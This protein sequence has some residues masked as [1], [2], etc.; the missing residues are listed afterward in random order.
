MEFHSVD[1]IECSPTSARTWTDCDLDTYIADLP[2]DV[3]G[4]QLSFRNTNTTLYDYQIAARCNGST[5]ELYKKLYRKTQT[6]V[7]IGVDASKIFEVKIENTTYIDVLISGYYTGTDIIF[8]VNPVDKSTATINEYVDV[9]CS[10]NVSSSAVGVFG[11]I[12]NNNVAIKNISIRKNGSTDDRYYGLMKNF[13]ALGFIIGIDENKIF[14]QKIESADI[15]IY[16]NGYIDSTAAVFNTNATD[17]SLTK[18]ATPVDLNALPSGA[19]AGIYEVVN[20]SSSSSYSYFLRKHGFTNSNYQIVNRRNY[21]VIEG[22]AQGQIANTTV[23]FWL[24]GYFL[25]ENSGQIAITPK[26]G[27]MLKHIATR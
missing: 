16:I 13:S 25:S 18:T 6:T 15:D 1:L 8:F 9:D 10:A 3:C 5:F 19:I 17:Y 4:V 7:S 24:I 27:K 12:C 23:D 26:Y 2:D 20:A 11:H 14:E 21:S 22:L